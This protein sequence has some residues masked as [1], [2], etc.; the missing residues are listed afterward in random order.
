MRLTEDVYI[1]GTLIP[2]DNFVYGVCTLSGERLKISVQSIRCGNS[3]FPVSLSGYDLDAIE[4]IRV[5]GAITRDAGKEGA[6]R[7]IQSIQMMSLDPNITTQAAAAGIE[8]TKGLLSK[9]VK[10]IRV[11]VKADYPLLLLDA[12]GVQ[13]SR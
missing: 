10:L 9:K 11:T 8:A 13:E 6:D 2:K 5:P 1:N 3:L 7:A 4:G 12:K